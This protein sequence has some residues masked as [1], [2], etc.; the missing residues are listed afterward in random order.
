[1]KVRTWNLRDKKAKQRTKGGH[2]KK[3]M[4]IQ[5]KQQR[6]EV[7]YW[8]GETRERTDCSGK[9]TAQTEEIVA[10]YEKIGER[11]VK[12]DAEQ[13]SAHSENVGSKDNTKLQTKVKIRRSKDINKP[14][15]ACELVLRSRDRICRKQN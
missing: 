12:S 10:Q 7:C 4:P 11:K 13:Y 1:M 8:C 14:R 3:P 2:R 5:K 6:K 9:T 15:S